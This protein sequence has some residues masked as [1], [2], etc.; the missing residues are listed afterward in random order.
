MIGH[1][2]DETQNVAKLGACQ[3]IL[4]ATAQTTREAPQKECSEHNL[5]S[6]NKKDF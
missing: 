2:Y 1:K 6:K 5:K 3:T 4:G